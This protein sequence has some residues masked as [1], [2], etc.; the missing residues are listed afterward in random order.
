M[1]NTRKLHWKDIN[2]TATSHVGHLGDI[3]YDPASPALRVSDGATPGGVSGVVTT[4]FFQATSGTK[5]YYLLP[6]DNV[7][8]V[9]IGINLTP[10]TIH[11][12][13]TA[14]EGKQYTI[15]RDPTSD[16]YHSVKIAAG[17]ATMIDNSTDMSHEW[18]N[19]VATFT[20]SGGQWWVTSYTKHSDIGG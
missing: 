5:D 11:L 12:P 4:K 7:I 15:K 10:V 13:G 16:G 9:N 18:G 3:F 17:G 6:E 19:S 8:I 14:V 2:D 1:A 20:F